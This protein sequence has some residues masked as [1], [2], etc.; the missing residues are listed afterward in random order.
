MRQGLSPDEA[1]RRV[2]RRIIKR[3]PQNLQRLVGFVALRA[4]G[5]M[6]YVS[7]IPGF[8]AAL[9]RA[10]KHEIADAPDMQ[11]DGG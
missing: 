3:D 5:Q 8:Q 11:A 4:D 7:T 2:L 9:S 1:I 10:G 6:G